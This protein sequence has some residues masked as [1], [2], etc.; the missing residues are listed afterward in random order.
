M[1]YS[2][3]THNFASIQTIILCQLLTP[4][5]QEITRATVVSTKIHN[6]NQREQK[7]VKVLEITQL[8]ALKDKQTTKQTYKNQ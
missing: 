2:K 3:H 4:T 6:T 5:E 1:R 8:E 7:L